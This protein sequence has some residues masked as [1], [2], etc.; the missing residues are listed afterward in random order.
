VVN[1]LLNIERFDL[2]LDYFR[3]YPDLVRAVTPEDVQATAGKYLHPDK[4]AVAI[5]G[6]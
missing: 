6:S 5:A 4:L 2:G 1:A 3:R